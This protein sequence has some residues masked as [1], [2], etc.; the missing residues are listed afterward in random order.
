LLPNLVEVEG[1]GGPCCRISS[2]L[3]TMA[4]WPGMSEDDGE[5]ATRAEAAVWSGLR[6]WSSS[7]RRAQRSSCRRHLLAG[8]VP[9]PLLSSGAS[10]PLRSSQSRSS[11]C[12]AKLA[13]VPGSTAPRHISPDESVG[14]GKEELRRWQVGSGAVSRVRAGYLHSHKDGNR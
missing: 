8:F 13:P 12:P 14:S 9:A 6:I 10:T 7:G 4:P 11:T 3:K 2:R 1:D 5:G